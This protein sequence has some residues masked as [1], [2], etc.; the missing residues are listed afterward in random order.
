MCAPCTRSV[1]RDRRGKII[2]SISQM[3]AEQSGKAKEKVKPV[4]GTG[5]AQQRTKEEQKA[6]EREISSKPLAQYEDDGDR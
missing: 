1:Y 6:Y 3:E 5:L 2:E 4:W